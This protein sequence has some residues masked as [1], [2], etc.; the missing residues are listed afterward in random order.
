MDVRSAHMRILWMLSMRWRVAL[1]TLAST[2][3]ALLKSA[4][5]SWRHPQTHIYTHTNRNTHTHTFRHLHM[6][7]E[8]ASP[9]AESG[10]QLSFGQ[11]L[12][13]AR[14]GPAFALLVSIQCALCCVLCVC[15]CEFAYENPGKA[16]NSPSLANAVIG[17]KLSTIIKKY[18]NK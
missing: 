14:Q 11:T 13:E 10:R 9:V 12:R 8:A 18:K 15:A 6:C 5:R 7:C 4:A 2:S 16:T 1:A 3:A 17:V